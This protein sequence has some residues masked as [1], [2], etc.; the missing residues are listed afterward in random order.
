M[1]VYVSKD[2]VDIREK[3]G[4]IKSDA[5][6]AGNAVLRAETPQ[7]QQRLIGHGRRNLI[8][9]GDMS[10]WQRGTSFTGADADQ[11]YSADRYS[12]SFFDDV[13]TRSVTRSTTAPRGFA[14]SMEL[15]SGLEQMYPSTTVE[16]PASGNPGVFGMGKEFTFSMYSDSTNA[17]DAFFIFRNG[18]HV[19]TNQVVASELGQRMHCI[20]EDSGNGFKRYSYTFT[21][22]DV[23]HADNICLTIAPRFYETSGTFRITGYQLEEGSTATSFEH[24]LA[25]EE[26]A[27]CRRYYMRIN[28][29]GGA[30]RVAIS[31][32]YSGTT[33]YSTL[34]FSTPMRVSPAIGYNS[35]QYIYFEPFNAGQ[36]SVLS[37]ASNTHTKDANGDITAATVLTTVTNGTS[38][39]GNVLLR[40]TAGVDY[41]DFDSEIPSQ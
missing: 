28:S 34:F 24:K 27:L 3:I 11:Y 25:G 31:G 19:G 2:S 9:N 29:I 36:Q 1:P 33:Q 14:Y 26:M 4:Q 37:L 20:E 5:G 40:G 17:P 38:Q 41:I 13:S 21:I 10:V 22:K 39:G 8:V 35:L 15:N 7:E 23:P 12:V 18:C 6:M 30:S 16:L 32:N